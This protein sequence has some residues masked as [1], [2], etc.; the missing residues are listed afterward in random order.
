MFVS[1]ELMKIRESK[2][3]PRRIPGGPV[4]QIPVLVQQP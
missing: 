4:K 3:P 2:G 1:R